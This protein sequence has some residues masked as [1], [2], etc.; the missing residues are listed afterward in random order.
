MSNQLATLPAGFGTPSTAFVDKA[1]DDLG[2]GIAASYGII[3]YRGKVWSIKYQGT[4]TPLMSEDGDTPRGSIEVVI[5]KASPAVSKIF[6]AGGYQDGSNSPPDCW[7]SNGVTPD[8][9]VKDK[10]NPTCAGCPRNVW[11]SRTTDAGKQGKQCSDSRRVA[12]S[13]LADIM[14]EVTGGPMLLRVPAASLKDLKGYGDMLNQHQFPYYAVAT[15]IKFDVKEAYPKFVFEAI[16]PLTEEEAAQV[17]TLQSDPRV[18]QL[19]ADKDHTT[20]DDAPVAPPKSLFTGTVVGTGTAKTA[21]ALTGAA[22]KVETKP[23]VEV[24]TAKAKP[25]PK[26]E[27]KP[28]AKAASAFAQA[29]KEIPPVIEDGSEDGEEAPDIKAGAVVQSTADFD[30]MLDSIL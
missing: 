13:P 7:S 21:Q 2:Q 10:Q 20:A 11:G 6:Y 1:N 8:A 29:T 3:G 18:H 23:K 5:V 12:V 22:P 4:E 25:E 30:A 17:I 14:S 27:L 19:L 24:K 26:A 9:S 16:R 15:K 28:A